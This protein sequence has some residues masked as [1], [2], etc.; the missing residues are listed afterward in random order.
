MPSANMVS[1]PIRKPQRVM[2]RRSSK[3][4]NANNKSY[5]LNRSV[6]SSPY[7]IKSATAQTLHFENGWNVIDASGGAAVSCIGHNNARVKQAMMKVLDNGTPYISSMMFDTEITEEFARF[8]VNT[9]DG[10][11]SKAVFYSSGTEANEAAFKAALQYHA[12]EKVN[13]EPS[14]RYFIARDRSYHGTTLG[15]LDM[16][17]HKARRALWEKVMPNNTRHI[18]PCYSYRSLKTGESRA[19][20]VT[21][22]KNELDDK[23]RELG[24]K[25]VAAFICEPVVGAALGCVPAEEGYLAAMREVCDRHG[26]LLIFDEVMCG[27]GR[28][29]YTHAWQ[30]EGVAPDIQTTGK[31]LAGGF[32]Q[33]SA[34]LVSPK[35]SDAFEF[36]PGSGAFSHGHT[37]QNYPLACAAGLEV[38]K[39]VQEEN[40]LQNVKEKGNRL[41]KMLHRRLGNHPNVGDIR[42]VGLFWGIEFVK[43][44][45]TMEPFPSALRV[46]WQIY[47]KGL[48]P[49]YEVHVYPGAGTVDGVNGDHIIVSPAYNITNADVDAIVDRVTRLVEDFFDTLNVP[50]PSTP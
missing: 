23:I 41:S 39:I 6:R 32:Q 11:M 34:M 36:G 4:T 18:S 49:P 5:L 10:K 19:E 1:S 47:E 50:V 25:N 33:I 38:Q 42:G 15:T 14:R 21:R 20:Y 17:G 2:A 43:D 45:Q 22:L 37:F 24:P 44:K 35:I 46:N 16:G 27:M 26:V 30:K 48:A 40:L 3:P 8:L 29:G 7:R 9:T 28:T 31:G 13:P 12:V